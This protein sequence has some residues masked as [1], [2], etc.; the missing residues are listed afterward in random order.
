MLFQRWVQMGVLRLRF[1][2]GDASWQDTACSVKSIRVVWSVSPAWEAVK[3]TQGGCFHLPVRGPRPYWFRS[4]NCGCSRTHA[5][6][7]STFPRCTLPA[8]LIKAISM[9]QTWHCGSV[10]VIV[11][12]WYHSCGVDPSHR[13]RNELYNY[14][15]NSLSMQC[16]CNSWINK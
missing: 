7:F 1:L 15:H 14:W 2:V 16:V 8:I 5:W 10:V 3:L 6:R 13:L 9:R 4:D 12:R 11:S